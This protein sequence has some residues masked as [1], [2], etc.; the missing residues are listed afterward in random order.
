MATTVPNLL[1]FEQAIAE[2]EPGK[3]KHVLLGN[4]FSRACRNDIFAYDALFK[5]ADFTKLPFAQQA[6]TALGTTDFEV[7][8]HALRRAAILVTVYAPTNSDLAK[9]FRDE[10]DALREVL[11]AAI[12]QNHPEYPAEIAPERYAACRRFLNYFNSAYTLN[13][14]LLLYWAIMQAEVGQDLALGDDGFRTPDDHS[15]TYVTWDRFAC[16]KP[17]RTRRAAQC[18]RQRGRSPDRRGSHS[19][20]F[21]QRLRFRSGERARTHRSLLVPRYNLAIH[22]H[23]LALLKHAVRAPRYSVG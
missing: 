16:H 17:K 20:E 19:N 9:L 11:A 23:P 4:G 14:D 7:V 12:A 2:A 5:R 22:P 13:Y 15:A 6:F 3:N 10:A 18:G 1:T 21:L 8:M